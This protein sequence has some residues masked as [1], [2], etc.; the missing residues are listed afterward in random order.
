MKI[1]SLSSS[2]AGPACA[3]ALC[4]K[5]YFYNNNAS[6]NIFDYLEISLESINQLLNISFDEID[7]YLRTNNEIYIN[8]DDYSSVLFKNFDKIISHH[9][10]TKEY[11]ELEYDNFIEKYKRRFYRFMNDLKYEDKIF[12]I[13]YG[14]DNIKSIEY[15]IEIIKNINSNLK[16]YYINVDFIES[17][18]L[19]IRNRYEINNYIYINFYKYLD[20]NQEYNEN[21]FYKTL[22]YDWKIVYNIIY[23]NLE[24]EYKKI[25]TYYQ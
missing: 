10:L 12:F 17:D 18:N 16:F 21:L 4:I 11:T 14:N 3:I 7:K 22:Q 25:F 9:D 5:K 24:E 20:K 13:R 6:T 23:E 19:E 2:I 1:V 15:F 8:K